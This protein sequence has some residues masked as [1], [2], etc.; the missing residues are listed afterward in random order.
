VLIDLHGG[1]FMGGARTVS[2]EEAI[3][4]ASTGKIKVISIDYRMWPEYVFPAA[5]E[6]VA[7]VYR[8]LLKNYR[9]EDM[10][11]Y[12]CSAGSLLTAQ[13]VAWFQ[14]QGL[15]M[16][17]A[18]GMFGGGATYYQEGD[19][20]QIASAR[21]AFP[22]QPANEHPYLD[23]TNGGN[24]LAFPVNVAD[25]MARFP[26]SLLI[27]ST[28]DLGLSS[29]VY[30][31]SQLVK[32]GVEAQ[33]N[34]WEGLQHCFLF[35]MDVPQS[36]EAFDV[37][38]R[39]FDQHLGRSSRTQNVSS[40]AV[41]EDSLAAEVDR[42][43]KADGASP[44]AP[45]Q[46][47]FVGSSS[48][49]VWQ[50]LA[51][52]MAPLPVINRGFGGSH[53]EY[54]NR[55]FNQIVA[56]YS[57]RAIVL[58]AGENDIDAGK[59]AEKVVADFDE[60][61]AKKSAALG[62]TPVYFISV[63]PSKLRWAQF[64]LQSEV[65]EAIR[66][67]SAQ[68]FDLHYVDVASVM[69]ENG[70]PKDLYLPDQLHMNSKGYALWTRALRIALVPNGQ[71]HAN[72][73]HSEAIEAT[74]FGTM[75]D[76]TPVELYTLRNAAG[77]AVKI[78]TY[79]G[80]V[81]SLTAPDRQG[82]LS[83]VVLGYDTLAG[84][85]KSSPYFGALIGRYGNRIA[86]G[87]FILNGKTYSLATNNGPNAL[88]GGLKGFDKVVWQVNKAERTALGPRL[89]LTYLSK[90]GEE[91]YP[92]NLS[93]TAVYTLTNE[94]AL[95]LDYTAT[96]DQATVVNLTQHSYFNLRGQGDILGH[97]VQINADR[98]TPVDGTL[99]P[100]GELRSVDGTPFDFRNPTA[101]GARINAEDEQLKAGKGY[102]HN[103]VIDGASGALRT[104]A[105]VYEPVTGR[106]LEVIS[107]EPGLQFYTGNFLDGTIT[108]KR[109]QVYAFR[110]GFCIEPQHYPDSPNQPSFP[111]VVLK[112][113]ETYHN[114][115]IYRFTA[116]N[117]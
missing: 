73:S 67:R 111:S 11:I 21:D 66:S 75:P 27:S 65:N 55:W 100:T 44:P 107:A 18:I 20:A 23:V 5:S 34:V 35:G 96:A 3:P 61:M 39:F 103:W 72:A 113:G 1:H 71:G 10:G 48:I 54:V 91:G 22:L 99:I 37:I 74:P 38:V 93:V 77:M 95:R 109:G 2:H 97:V 60:F 102:D 78:A 46:V 50:S 31:H 7:A 24:P 69:L 30:T 49:A 80:I 8:E 4:I 83:D 13:S 76:G 85:L 47:L 114:T 43:V 86:Q 87:R 12:G 112:P 14:K 116:R 59:S 81:T 19:S 41:L 57:P 84:Y 98:F 88:H 68:R 36:A 70:K 9:P 58:Y 17:G 51:K 108:G 40:T 45:G 52:D 82:H 16:P 32:Q 92:G 101:I 115:I 28:R 110:S 62:Q 104:Q 64:K 33:L 26:P 15:P 94:N 56:P 79:G 25:V 89:T 117:P 53:I 29:V 105:T 6:D 42:F 63:K 90:D 106:T